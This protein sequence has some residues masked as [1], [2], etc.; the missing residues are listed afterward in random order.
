MMDG[1]EIPPPMATAPP[2]DIHAKIRLMLDCAVDRSDAKLSIIQSISKKNHGAALATDLPG[3]LVLE[4]KARL[5]R[6]SDRRKSPL[7]AGKGSLVSQAPIN[8]IDHSRA[9][10]ISNHIIEKEKQVGHIL[11]DTE[12]MNILNE[13]NDSDK[14]F[15]EDNPHMESAVMENIKAWSSLFQPHISLAHETWNN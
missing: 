8:T 13:Q 10:N 7:D 11:S 14:V 1:K 4:A 5:R 6:S 15:E 2:G 3:D 9:G 12:A